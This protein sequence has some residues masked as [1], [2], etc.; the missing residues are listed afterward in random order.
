MCRYFNFNFDNPKCRVYGLCALK[1]RITCHIRSNILD[2]KSILS[3]AD[4]LVIF[5]L[6][7]ALAASEIN[8]D[9]SLQR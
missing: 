1:T 3:E 6:V 9:G 7:S 8:Q 5:W 2:Y 4:W